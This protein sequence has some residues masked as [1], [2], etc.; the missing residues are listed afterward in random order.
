MFCNIA[1]YPDH[2]VM[3][4]PTHE[5]VIGRLWATG[6]SIFPR[7]ITAELVEIIKMQSQVTS[8]PTIAVL[9]II[10]SV[11]PRCLVT[12]YFRVSLKKSNSIHRRSIVRVT[13][14]LDVQSK[15]LLFGKKKN[16]LLEHFKEKERIKE[17]TTKHET[18]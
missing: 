12:S 17:E 1:G 3:L 16:P 13:K 18:Y 15:T 2:S 6:F 8:N 14:E 11:F 7:K 4:S 10:A 5:T 9:N